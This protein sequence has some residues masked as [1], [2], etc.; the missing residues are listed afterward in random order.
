MG[1]IGNMLVFAAA[2]PVAGIVWP[3]AAAAQTSTAADLSVT[4]TRSPEP[5]HV[6]QPLV[7]TVR[8]R[9]DGP[10]EASGVA[11]TDTLPAGV[12]L[13]SVSP[14][15]GTCRSAPGT[16][17]CHP[18]KLSA[19]ATAT[20]RIRVV[21]TAEGTVTNNAKV[22]AQSADPN[23]ANNQ[24]SASSTVLAA[25]ADVV[26]G[27][28]APSTARLGQPVVYVI[29]GTNRGPSRADNVVVSAQF[30]PGTTFTLP[31]GCSTEAGS[32]G[33]VVSCPAGAL[34]A[35]R[36]R[37]FSLL[38]TFTT[39]GVYDIGARADSDTADPNYANNLMV[40]RTE[41]AGPRAD[42]V[43]AVTGPSLAAAGRTV[44]YVIQGTN[45]GPDPA[46]SAVVS[47]RFPT[48]AVV[49]PV[50]GCTTSSDSSGT[51]VTCPAGTLAPGASARYSVTVGFPFTGR[52]TIAARAD[53][54]TGDSNLANNLTSMVTA[55]I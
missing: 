29:S 42:M 51:V 44:T 2:L 9:N 3:P 40:L 11:I 23:S 30:P 20:V 37:S 5:V 43:A 7:E 53:S 4:N 14:S 16:V 27:L 21:P 48:G 54:S 24:A 13:L 46:M 33:V 32:S 6:A 35:N 52:Y 22:T 18:G 34:A 1:R 28:V 36:G 39:E 31:S 47:A 15:Q 10:A 26:A 49:A 17:V 50:A 38:V 41:A 8:V 12:R 55:V 25:S 45:K 19:G